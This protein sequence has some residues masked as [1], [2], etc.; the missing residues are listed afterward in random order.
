MNLAL[1]IRA[2]LFE[3]IFQIERRHRKDDD[4]ALLHVHGTG[5]CEILRLCAAAAGAWVAGNHDGSDSCELGGGDGER[6]TGR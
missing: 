1:L 6:G 2:D 5:L 3:I 4:E